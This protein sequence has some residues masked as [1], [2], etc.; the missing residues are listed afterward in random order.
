MN[1]TLAR[2]SPPG[3][4]IEQISSGGGFAPV[5]G[6]EG[7]ELFYRAGEAWSEMMVMP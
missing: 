3:P 5:W 2:L 1:P 7:Q 6:P 4:G